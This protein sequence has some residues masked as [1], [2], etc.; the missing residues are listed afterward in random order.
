VRGKHWELLRR[1]M[2]NGKVCDACANGPGRQDIGTSGHQDSGL[3]G[4]VMQVQ[5]QR[6]RHVNDAFMLQS[7][8]FCSFFAPPLLWFF[9][10]YAVKFYDY[11]QSDKKVVPQTFTGV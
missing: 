5:R 1:Q 6:Q 8:F 4:R 11:C 3:P 10:S 2:A 9:V 7:R